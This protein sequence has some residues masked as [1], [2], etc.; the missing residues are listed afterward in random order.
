MLSFFDKRRFLFV[1]FIQVILVDAPAVLQKP[2]VCVT[3]QSATEIPLE[4]MEDAT[5]LEVN[6]IRINVIRTVGTPA[7][8]ALAM[9]EIA[10][11]IN[12]TLRAEPISVQIRKELSFGQMEPMEDVHAT[13]AAATKK[14]AT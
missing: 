9:A 7:V 14:D 13:E 5:A 3:R 11:S 12:V 6:V 4:Q 10:R 1:M 8:G 2:Q